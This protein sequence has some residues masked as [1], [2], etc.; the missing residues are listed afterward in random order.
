MNY[1]QGIAKI[2]NENAFY[3]Y[4]LDHRVSLISIHLF[5]KLHNIDQY[6]V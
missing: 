6:L 2:A 3:G 4:F 5:H 1:D